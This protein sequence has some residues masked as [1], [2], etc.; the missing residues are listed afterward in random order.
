MAAGET[1]PH[2]EGT[3]GSVPSQGIFIGGLAVGLLAFMLLFALTVLLAA[4]MGG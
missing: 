3:M 4:N 1:D 2:G